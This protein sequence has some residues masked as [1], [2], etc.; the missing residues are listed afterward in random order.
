MPMTVIEAMAAARPVVATRVGALDQ[1]VSDGDTGLLV[2][3][4]DESEFTRALLSI[5]NDP[6][7]AAEMGGRARKRAAE[8]FSAETMAKQYLELYQRL[9]PE[10]A[11]C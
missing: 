5:V 2:D 9:C 8:R 10:P 11:L 1:V 7:A 6:V 4:T 3:E